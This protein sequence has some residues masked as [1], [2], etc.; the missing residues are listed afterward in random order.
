LFDFMVND[1]GDAL[2]LESCTGIPDE[3]AR[4]IS[5]LEFGQAVCGTVAL[6]RQPVVAT[7]IQQS[8]DPKVQLVKS[9]GIRA[10]ACNPLLAE[11]RLLGTLSFASRTREQFDADEL[12]FLRTITH[13]VTVAY[14][15]LRLVKELRDR[16]RRKDEFLA[17]LAHELRNP[18]APIRNAV[19]VLKLRVRWNR[20]CR[21][22][23]R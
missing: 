21:R 1:A 16:D 2:R 12:E 19:Q 8:D 23:G 3:T 14:E 10:Y 9:F 5:R 15:R 22:P 11:E 6:H 18:L 17:M 7:F 4:S 13:Y 20:P